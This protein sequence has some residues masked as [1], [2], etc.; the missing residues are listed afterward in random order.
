MNSYILIPGCDD[1]NRGDQA[2][3]WE[4][5]RLAEEAGFRG[6]YSMVSIGNSAEQSFKQGISIMAPVLAHPSRK[7]KNKNNSSY[8]VN[9]LLKWGSI[10][11]GDFLL[12]RLIYHKPTRKL[13]WKFLP[14]NLQQSIEQMQNC[15]AC[16]VKG[17]G[18]VHSYGKITDIYMIYFV[19]YHIRLALKMGKKVYVMPNSFG[20]FMTKGVK[21]QV[22][23]ALKKCEMV[24]V[25]E[26]ISHDMLKEI[27]IDSL[28]YPDLAFKL[29]KS[30]NDV[31]E[32]NEIKKAAAGRK[33]VAITARPYRFPNCENPTAKYNDYINAM[34]EFAKWVYEQGYFPV[35]VEHVI[36]RNCHESDIVSLKE[37]ASGLEDSKY[38]LS[39][40]PSYSCRQLKELYSNMDF[41]VGTRFHSVIFSLASGVPAIAIAYGGNKTRGIMTDIGLSDYIIDMDKTTTAD[42]VEKFNRL[43]LNKEQIKETL[44]CFEKQSDAERTDLINKLKDDTV[45]A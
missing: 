12:S 37:I 3:V 35:L 27:G 18:F 22:K 38:Y 1:G 29:S 13:I 16:F 39:S 24:T 30:E 23:K 42:L 31:T 26:S 19:L 41:I 6:K 32:I 36:S 20:P 45:N 10:A 40:N 9:L 8:T 7:F 33:L 44:A 17:G 5:K 14:S 34:T 15:D 21:Y 2:L 43:I 28:V 4:T 25:R 11:V